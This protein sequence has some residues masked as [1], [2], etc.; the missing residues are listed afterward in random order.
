M[1]RRVLAID[2]GRKRVGLAW[3]DELGVIAS[4]ID[5]LDNDKHLVKKV[6]SFIIDNEIEKVV[7]G[8]PLK[9]S[10]DEGE[11]SQEI[12]DFVNSL[13]NE[14]KGVEFVFIDESLTSKDAEKIYFEKFRRFPKTHSEKYVIDSYA[15]AIILQEYLDSKRGSYE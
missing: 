1:S 3:S 5:A 11:L 13:R 8:I 6:V 9:M 14:L 10:G 15:A 7:V 2:Y 4:P 12:R